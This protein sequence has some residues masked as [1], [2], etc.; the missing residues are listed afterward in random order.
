MPNS[1]QGTGRGHLDIIRE[2]VGDA[3]KD[4]SKRIYELF[5]EKDAVRLSDVLVAVPHLKP[6][7][8]RNIVR[9]QAESSGNAGFIETIARW[10]LRN[11]D[12]SAQS[13]ETLAFLANL[14]Q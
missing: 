4:D 10:N 1:T 13:E 3:L 14:L 7:N 9:G 11:D 8:G 12:L 2:R 5:A 6:D